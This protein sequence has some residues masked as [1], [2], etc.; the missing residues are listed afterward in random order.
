LLNFGNVLLN[1]VLSKHIIPDVVIHKLCW[2]S[3]LQRRLSELLVLVLSRQRTPYNCGL[4]T[5]TTSDA[6]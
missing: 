3:L 1:D 5:V 4:S 6:E 2:Y